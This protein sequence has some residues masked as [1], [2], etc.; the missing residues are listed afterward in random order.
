MSQQHNNECHSGMMAVLQWI[1][2][3]MSMLLR[4]NLRPVHGPGIPYFEAL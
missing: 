2:A 4:P 1:N 3:C